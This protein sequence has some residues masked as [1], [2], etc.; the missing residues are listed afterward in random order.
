MDD[1]SREYL[2]HS[3]LFPNYVLCSTSPMARY[4]ISNLYAADI[5]SILS[6][7]CSSYTPLTV[8]YRRADKSYSID[9]FKF[10][11]VSE[12]GIIGAESNIATSESVSHGLGTN[13]KTIGHCNLS[14]STEKWL[15]RFVH[16]LS[17][18]DH[19]AIDQ[20]FVQIVFLSSDEK[21]VIA[22]S[23]EVLASTHTSQ[24]FANGKLDSS[25]PVVYVVI[26]ASSGSADENS[27]VLLMRARFGEE[28]VFSWKPSLVE[29][30]EVQQKIYKQPQGSAL[31][32][33]LNWSDIKFLKHI[34]DYALGSQGI[35][36]AVRKLEQL[37]ACIKSKRSGI[38]GH[39]RN[40]W[41]TSEAASAI[42]LTSV[43][44]QTRLAADIA[45]HLRRYEVGLE[46]FSGLI[47]DFQHHGM[48]AAAASCSMMGAFCKALASNDHTE[49]HRLFQGS[50]DLFLKCGQQKYNFAIRSAVLSCLLI[51][52]GD[53][54]L[55]FD[56]LFST[57][58]TAAAPERAVLHDLC[59]QFYSSAGLTRKSMLQSVL[60]GH[61][62]REI[63]QRQFALEHYQSVLNYFQQ[64]NWENIQDHLLFSLAKQ[65]YI[66]ADLNGA[67]LHFIAL[68]SGRPT[69]Y[70]DR[71]ILS[72]KHANYLR[73]L[74]SVMRSASPS[75]AIE[76]GF[77]NWEITQV[78]CGQETVEIH[79][80]KY[81]VQFGSTV[82]VFYKVNNFMLVPIEI[83]DFAVRSESGLPNM[84]WSV[85]STVLAAES[86]FRVSFKFN[87]D[88]D[89]FLSELSWRISSLIS[90]SQLLGLDFVVDHNKVTVAG[91]GKEPILEGARTPF[92]ILIE[93]TRSALENVSI[94][95]E[96]IKE[97]SRCK[98]GERIIAI[99]CEYHAASVLEHSITIPV[100][101]LTSGNNRYIVLVPVTFNVIRGPRFGEI[102]SFGAAFD[103]VYVAATI[104]NP[105]DSLINC[106]RLLFEIKEGH[107]DGPNIS[108]SPLT[109]TLNSFANDKFQVI[110]KS[111]I[112]YQQSMDFA[113]IWATELGVRGEVRRAIN[114]SLPRYPV[115]MHAQ[116]PEIVTVGRTFSFCC[117]ISNSHTNDFTHMEVEICDEIDMLEIFGPKTF[118]RGYIVRCAD[119]ISFECVMLIN[120]A[121]LFN[122]PNF[123]FKI[124]DSTGQN[125]SF[126]ATNTQQ[127]IAR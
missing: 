123:D 10:K 97:V 6:P 74:L 114:N 119:Q 84:E 85:S 83:S 124:S 22:A 33:F 38:R 39:F 92:E 45:F 37:E 120:T 110:S 4:I 26:Q 65:L 64:K 55:S 60:A 9:D 91:I 11:I 112:D 30:L 49:V 28:N 52:N 93:N 15:S 34:L 87:V 95:S 25:F 56:N 99:D 67:L 50:I 79:D 76:L 23:E 63:G 107:I 105:S 73:G 12:S 53:A 54:A 58:S 3:F 80:G 43:Y 69:L 41:K 89:I 106:R 40:F 78:C 66:A 27:S 116:Y 72:E 94:E 24:K 98:I 7:L 29:T 117:T 90:C 35:N 75:K 125:L 8:H 59:S 32:A 108:T 46:Y 42:A 13:R 48:L 44:W 122:V 21:D 103:A 14:D 113:V 102:A 31:F 16:T 126:K 2:A 81:R 111:Q 68:F 82:E 71:D 118:Q 88:T 19:E 104:V 57:I 5:Q 62:F 127:I 61:T 96:F 109:E 115:Y 17:C 86:S 77:P 18:S 1:V 121:G 51:G 20:P 101:I 47:T 36:W 70:T 100:H